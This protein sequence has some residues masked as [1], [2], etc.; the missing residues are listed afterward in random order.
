MSALCQSAGSGT[1]GVELLC[2]L[3]Q[4]LSELYGQKS[5]NV[6]LV[7]LVLYILVLPLRLSAL[8]CACACVRM[9]VCK[10]L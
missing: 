10:P 4:R 8:Q 1:G 5:E 2:C 9:Y 3:H 7:K 6:S